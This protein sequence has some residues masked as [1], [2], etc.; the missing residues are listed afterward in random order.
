MNAT[1]GYYPN[2]GVREALFGNGLTETLALNNRMQPCRANV[3][4]SAS[5][6][7]HCT[8]GV[9][10]GNVLDFTVGYNGGSADNGNV[11]S[12]SAVGN[13]TFNRTYVYDSLNRIQSMADSATGQACQGMSWT[14]D[15]WGNLTNQTGTKGTCLSF[16]AAVGTNNQLQSGYVYDAAGNLTYDGVHHYTY[17]AE[18][19]IT[20]VDSGSTASYVYNENG[21]RVR[22]N[23]GATWT[24]YLYGPIG[25]VLE[26]W[27][28]SSWPVQYVYAGNDLIAE[29]TTSTTEFVHTD[30]LGS[31]RLLTAVN[32]SIVDS[33]DYLPFGQQIAGDTATTHSSPAKNAIPNPASITSTNGTTLRAWGDSCPPI[34]CSSV[35]IV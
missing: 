17:D 16:S 5:Y 21:K 10:S 33:L 23:T 2:G 22:R 13:Q 20:Q 8:D 32:K 26:E 34:R 19:R 3:N 11:A 29:Y 4:S 12:W 31:T 6:F 27:N 15:A 7:S 25:L 14:I 28:G 18:N 30:H 24:E 9:P 35:R 1:N